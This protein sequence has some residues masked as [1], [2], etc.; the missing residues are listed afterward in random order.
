[1]DLLRVIGVAPELIS[2]HGYGNATDACRRIA[3][4]GD[5]S[6]GFFGRLHVGDQ[7]IMGADVEETFD[8]KIYDQLIAN[9]TASALAGALMA[10]AVL[11]GGDKLLLETLSHYGES[12]G[13]AFQIKDDIL[14]YVNVSINNDSIDRNLTLPLIHA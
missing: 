3:G 4:G 12:V 13:R 7:E 6:S 9:K 2:A 1:M 10:G 11:A 8:E 14:D 5:G